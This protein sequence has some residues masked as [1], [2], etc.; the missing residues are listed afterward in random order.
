MYE[1]K[2]SLP[3]ITLPNGDID[4][5]DD[6]SGAMA[7]YHAFRAYEEKQ[8]RER[9]LS[10]K[11][12]KEFNDIIEKAQTEQW[13]DENVLKRTTSTSENIIYKL[14]KKYAPPPVPPYYCASYSAKK[15]IKCN[16]WFA[17]PDPR[18]PY[19]R[20]LGFATLAVPNKECYGCDRTLE[21]LRNSILPS[22]ELGYELDYELAP[23]PRPPS[24]RT[25][26][27][28]IEPFEEPTEDVN[29]QIHFNE[30]MDAGDK[31]TKRQLIVKRLRA[32][33]KSKRDARQRY[34]LP[35]TAH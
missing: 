19:Q 32:V 5:I 31:N 29:D 10:K 16:K 28:R 21:D 34:S 12:M 17:A 33:L 35:H 11:E 1:L 30:I 20:S 4:D 8:E 3:Q 27:F 18:T 25:K 6:S 23:A 22:H 15:C 24:A 13:S 2:Q 9:M 7:R 14:I 26:G